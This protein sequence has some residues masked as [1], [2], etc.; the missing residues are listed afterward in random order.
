MIQSKGLILVEPFWMNVVVIGLVLSLIYSAENEL[1]SSTFLYFLL[2]K[3]T[4]R[5]RS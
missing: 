3:Q 1:T 2:P 4:M 5:G